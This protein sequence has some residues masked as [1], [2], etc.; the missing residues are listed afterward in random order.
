MF[1][2]PENDLCSQAPTAIGAG[3]IPGDLGFNAG[4]LGPTLDYHVDVGLARWVLSV[5]LPC[6]GVGKRGAVGSESFEA[7]SHS[8]YIGLVGYTLRPPRPGKAP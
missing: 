5:S 3:P 4:V 2:T 8:S 1:S 6:L 7:L